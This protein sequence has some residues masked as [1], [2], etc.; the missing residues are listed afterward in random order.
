MSF[1]VIAPS[2]LRPV[3]DEV[4]A[5]L[6]VGEVAPPAGVREVRV[7]GEVFQFPYRTYYAPDTLQ[8]VVGSCAGTARTF[9]LGMCTRHWEGR[10]REWAVKEMDPTSQAWAPAFA[11]QLLGEYVL[12]IAQVVE[13]KISSAGTGL[14]LSFAAQNLAF[15]EVTERRAVSYWNCYYRPMFKEISE[16]PNYRAVIALKAAARTAA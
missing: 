15:L 11:I 4:L 16:F 6:R 9:A 8:S 2:E 13:A 1:G 14:Y 7:Q 12:E 3:A 10:I 5:A